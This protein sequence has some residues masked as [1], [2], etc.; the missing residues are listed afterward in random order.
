LQRGLSEDLLEGPLD[1]QYDPTVSSSAIDGL[2]CLASE[3]Q[4]PSGAWVAY[5]QA[6]P[7]GALLDLPGADPGGAHP[8]QDL[9]G[10]GPECFHI[11]DGQDLACGTVAF[12]PGSAH[13]E[14]S[15][16]ACDRKQQ[17]AAARIGCPQGSHP[18]PC[19]AK[20]VTR[21]IRIE[22]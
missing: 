14:V 19:V 3:W 1:V 22:G 17:S 18:S 16:F 12:V 10:V 13:P 21:P 5:P 11:A 6:H 20:R 8:Y 9:T 15:S 4:A 7:A 2:V